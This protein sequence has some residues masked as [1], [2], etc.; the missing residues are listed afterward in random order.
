MKFVLVML[1]EDERAKGR[2]V[3]K[4][5]KVR[6]DMKYIEH[7]SASWQKLR[8]NA[9]RFKKDPKIKN[10]ILVRRREEVQ[11]VKL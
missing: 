1:D 9:A 8:D 11:V 3:M 5:V 2:G 10:F 7:E 6:W 4:R